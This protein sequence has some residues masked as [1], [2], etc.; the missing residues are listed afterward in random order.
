MGQFSPRSVQRILRDKPSQVA[1]GLFVAT[2]AHAM[3]AMRDVRIGGVGGGGKG[4]VPGLAVVVRVML[5]LSCYRPKLPNTAWARTDSTSHG[6][7][8]RPDGDARGRS[9]RSSTPRSRRCGS[10]SARRCSGSRGPTTSR[11]S[12]CGRVAAR[13]GA[14]VPRIAGCR[15]YCM[16]ARNR[17]SARSTSKSLSELAQS[18]TSGSAAIARARW[19]IASSLFPANAW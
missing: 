10:C 1:I 3:V 13:R 17:G 4:T 12:R 19:S 6:R 14:G 7:P 18:F 9:A 5:K 15:S 8:W 16:A 2:F 11:G